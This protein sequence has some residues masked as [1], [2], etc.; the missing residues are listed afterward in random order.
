VR[1]S[2]VIA[3]GADILHSSGKI[4]KATREL[5]ED[6]PAIQQAW[7]S[8]EG[9]IFLIQERDSEANLIMSAATGET[10]SIIDPTDGTANS[11]VIFLFAAEQRPTHHSQPDTRTETVRRS[12]AIATRLPAN[13]KYRQPP[14]PPPP[15]PPPPL[16]QPAE[17]PDRLIGQ[18][19]PEKPVAIRCHDQPKSGP[20]LMRYLKS[21]HRFFNNMRDACNLTRRATPVSNPEQPPPLPGPP[22]PPQ[23]PPPPPPATLGEW[24][25][26]HSSDPGWPDVAFWNL[27]TEPSP[28]DPNQQGWIRGQLTEEKDGTI[29]IDNEIG[30][31]CSFRFPGNKPIMRW[32]QVLPTPS[33][34]PEASTKQPAKATKAHSEPKPQKLLTDWFK[35][36]TQ[37][38]PAQH[39]TAPTP[40]P[41]VRPSTAAATAAKKAGNYNLGD[42]GW[43]LANDRIPNK[44]AAANIWACPETDCHYGVSSNMGDEK[45]TA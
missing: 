39:A 26:E 3:H 6:H 4:S 21:I 9:S 45:G 20:K 19:I 14:P 5:I 28:S 44:P 23:P 35:A 7:G 32:M 30:F 31:P 40:P 38:P 33:S 11:E 27:I 16:P 2:E 42:I 34:F 41:R 36:G 22:P 17:K 24:V 15:L 12:D 8:T 43:I 10:V 37:K 18:D 13:E 29:N 25:T 1:A